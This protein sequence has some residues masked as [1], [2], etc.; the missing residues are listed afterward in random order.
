MEG[1]R[2]FY[3]RRHPNTPTRRRADRLVRGQQ[4]IAVLGVQEHRRTVDPQQGVNGLLVHDL[5][6]AGWRFHYGGGDAPGQVVAAR[7]ML[8]RN[9]DPT[10]EPGLQA[11]LRDAYEQ[12]EKAD[13]QQMVKDPHSCQQKHDG[14]GAWFWYKRLGHPDGLGRPHRH[15]VPG[16]PAKRLCTWAGPLP[17]SAADYR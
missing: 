17:R 3:E 16:A 14:K 2:S 15:D 13:A 11:A 8:R 4:E 1:A 12:A 10:A 6:H 5:G 7:Q 9:R